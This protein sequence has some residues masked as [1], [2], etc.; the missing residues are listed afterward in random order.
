MRED[1][2]RY[3]ICP[4]CKNELIIKDAKK[5]A[6]N[7]I[8][9]GIL[10]CT[11]CLR[12][13]PIINHIPRFVLP[14]NYSNSFGLEW[15]KHSRTQYDSYSGTNVSR[16]RFFNETGWP[17]NLAGEI[18]L[19]AGCGSGRF[20]E[21]AAST[22]AFV[23][24]FDLSNAVEANYASNGKKDNVFILQADLFNMPFRKDYFDKLFCLGVLQHTPDPKKAFLALPG[25]LKSGG[26]I[27]IDVYRKYGFWFQILNTKYWFRPITRRMNSEILYRLVSKYVNL[28]WPVSKLINRLPYGRWINV[29]LLI[30]DYRGVYDLNEDTLKEWA[31]LDSFDKLSPV[32]DRP[33]TLKAVEGWFEEAGMTAA[34]IQFGFNGI[35]GQAKKIVT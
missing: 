27:V 1:S 20:T 22:G 34:N 33:Q 14:E 11:K 29:A 13:Y 23:V 31:I 3:I 17:K 19:E 35:Y 25:Y 24:S 12:V 32:Y 9:S 7:E 21:Q 6:D 10:E 26:K 16:T 15:T 2:I 4:D 18:I 28:M 8:K 5:D 30:A